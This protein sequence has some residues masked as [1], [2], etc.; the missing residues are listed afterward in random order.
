MPKTAQR[1]WSETLL[2]SARCGAC[3]GEL[4]PRLNLVQLQRRATWRYPTGGNLATNY[5][6]CAVAIVCD[7]CVAGDG[8]PVEAVE[9]TAGEIVYH[10]IFDLEP[11]GPEPTAIVASW[12]G[13]Q[14]IRCLFC[15]LTSF[16]PADV[17]NRYC[18]HCKH[19]HDAVTEAR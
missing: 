16:Q 17:A 2:L 3:R 10:P 1:S 19:F 4:G 5:G 9:L 6:P 12:Q 11:L 18:G 14:G 13:G 15:G 7:R 8:A